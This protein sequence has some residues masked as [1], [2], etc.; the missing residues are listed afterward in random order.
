MFTQQLLG[1]KRTVS[2]N[3]RN[4][5]FRF[6]SNDRRERCALQLGF[7]EESSCKVTQW[8]LL[9]RGDVGGVG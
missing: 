1:V 6:S 4:L 7:D 8:Q 3:L 5:N 2:P 9:C